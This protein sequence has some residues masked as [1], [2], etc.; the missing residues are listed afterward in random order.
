[1]VGVMISVDMEGVA[2]VVHTD[3]T[4]R[5]GLDYSLARSLMTGEANAAIAGAFDAGAETVV[6]NDSHG[7]MRN[8]LPEELDP[9][10]MLISGSPKP[11]LMMQGVDEPKI[12]AAL[13]IGYHPRANSPGVLDHTIS[14]AFLRELRINGE[15]AGELD[16]NA[17]IAGAFDVPI[18]MLSGDDTA[19]AQAKERVPGI[20][21]AIVKQAINRYAARNSAPQPARDLIRI[22]ARRGVDRRGA[23]RPVR[24]ETPVTLSVTGANSGVAD[25]IEFMPGVVRTDSETIEY[26]SEDFIEAARAFFAMVLLAG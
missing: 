4:R 19:V 9:R 16:L 12:E 14:G 26:T 11:L 8:L 15:P 10:A 25:R 17:G 5:D 2:G 3:H 24:Y 1:M 22:A 13:C 23:I 7:T 6:V 20:E 21:T 18:V